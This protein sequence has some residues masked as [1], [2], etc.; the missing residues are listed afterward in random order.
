MRAAA[1]ARIIPRGPVVSLRGGVEARKHAVH[2][3]RQLEIVPDDERRVR[4]VDQVI[5]RDAAVFDGIADDAAEERD[6][7]AGADLAEDI[8]Y[9]PRAPEARADRDHFSVPPALRFDGPL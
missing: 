2:I 6:V 5:F 7:R 1:G 3:S 4:V 8:R 9:P